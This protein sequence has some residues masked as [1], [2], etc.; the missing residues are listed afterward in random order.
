MRPITDLDIVGSST[1][2][3]TQSPSLVAWRPVM[4]LQVLKAKEVLDVMVV[5]PALIYGRSSAI[6]KSFFNPVIE[7]AKSKTRSVQIPLT[8]GYP[9][10]IHVDDVAEGLHKAINKLPHFFGTGVFPVFNLASQT[11]NM[12]DVFNAFAASVD[13]SGKVELVG[14]GDN[15]FAQAM[16]TSGNIDVGRAKSLLKWQPKR[17]GFVLGMDVYA[18]AFATC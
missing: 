11:E 9:S 16:S 4:E 7:A 14:P 1:L 15:A 3:P 6:W 18:K 8:A 10:L 5:R 13:Y 12:Q 17:M 2:S